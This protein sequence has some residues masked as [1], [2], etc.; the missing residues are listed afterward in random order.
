MFSDTVRLQ[1]PSRQPKRT[2]I[3]AVMCT[4]WRPKEERS[5]WSGERNGWRDIGVSQGLRLPQ[6]YFWGLWHC[7]SFLELE[8][9]RCQLIVQS[10]KDQ[11]K[12]VLTCAHGDMQVTKAF[13]FKYYLVT[14]LVSAGSDEQAKGHCANQH[15]RVSKACSSS[16]PL[17]VESEGIWG[18]L[19]LQL[20]VLTEKTDLES[21]KERTY[22]GASY[23]CCL[24]SFP[25]LQWT[26]VIRQV[27]LGHLWT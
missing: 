7:R 4:Y 20:N 14:N 23:L 11:I 15:V 10:G 18:H 9:S 8:I 17:H 1:R 26:L 22:C 16:W 12:P 5:R 24:F 25:S 3:L 19:W 21:S 6:A 2:E 27:W 13:P